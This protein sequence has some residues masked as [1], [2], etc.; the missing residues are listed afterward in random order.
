MCAGYAALPHTPPQRGAH[1]GTP[2]RNAAIPRDMP[3]LLYFGA[4]FGAC[5]D[6]PLQLAAARYSV[7]IRGRFW[8]DAKQNSLV[9]L[10]DLGIKEK[11]HDLRNA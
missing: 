11:S 2:L 5:H 1:M 10:L 8:Y 3:R 6:T 9:L 7:G 4:R